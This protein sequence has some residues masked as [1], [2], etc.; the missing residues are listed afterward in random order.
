MLKNYIKIAWRNITK[1]KVFASINI[2]GLAAGMAVAMLIAF[3]VWDEITYNKNFSNH[4]EIAQVMTTFYINN[5]DVGTDPAVSMPIGN[6]LRTKYGSDF[7]NVS[8]ASWNFDHVIATGE[9]KITAKGMW[10]EQ[11][12]PSMFSLKM[13]SGTDDGLSEP[14]NILINA[15]LAKSLF[16]NDDPVNKTVRIDGRDDYKVSGVFK[17]FAENTTFNDVQIFLPWKKYITSSQ[18]LERA[19]TQWNNHSFQAYVQ[20]ADH[21]NIEQETRKIKD[22]AMPHKNALTEGKEEAY[23]FPMDQWRLY[24]EF[25]NGKPS[26]GRIQFVW[27]FSIIGVFVIILACI[28]FMNLS[29]ARSEKRAKEVGIRKTIGSLRMQLINQF[30]SESVLIALFSL[31]FSILFVLLLMPVFNNLADKNMAIPWGNLYFWL[32][33]IAF[34]ITTGLIAGSYPALYL[35]KFKPIKVLKGTFISGKLSSLPRK[36]LVVVQFTFSIALIIGTLIV[37]KQIQ[38][39]KNRPVN[40]K[41]E[42]LITVKVNTRDLRNHLDA[43]RTD[44][45][46]TG[47]IEDAAVSSSPTTAVY[48]NQIGFN[49]QG[50]DPNTLPAF[51]TINVG[52]DFG[53]TI[54]WHVME[55]R[56]FSKEF[57]TD[58]SAMILNEAA[59]RQIN[60]KGNIIGKT[61][62]FND[63]NFTVIGVVKDMVMESPYKPVTPTVFF[64]SSAQ[65]NVITISIRKGIPVN[66]ALTKIGSVFKKYNPEAPFDYTFN[67]ETYA[68]KFADEERIGNLS[69]FFTILAI[70]ISCLGLFGLA[71]FVAEQRRKEIGVRKVLGA[72]TFNLWKL[73]SGEFTLLVFISC[74]IAIPLAWYYLNGWLQQYEYRTAI[75]FWIFIVSGLGALMITLITVSFQAIKAA[76]ANPVKSLRTE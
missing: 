53:K 14:T 66:T 5:G 9:K 67:E 73:L 11:S 38:F 47:V 70:F 55:G 68:R 26:G 39:A 19:S 71:S 63:N 52:D 61:I 23:L 22:I 51:G 54:G 72:S 24:G 6:E 46:S 49:W 27:L 12:F 7:K 69:S 16:G 64:Y 75:P 40:Y 15:S 76:V 28:N 41:K 18:G 35:S 50:K 57:A 33:A 8:M 36:I 2:L 3:W 34:T 45:I 1:N 29:T 65:P 42:G 37:Y 60:M 17:D 30:L 4:R 32:I 44:L 21:I 48:A 74:F 25:K 13:I 62:Q 10:V 31:I 56:D 58:S 20:V 59:V 43:V